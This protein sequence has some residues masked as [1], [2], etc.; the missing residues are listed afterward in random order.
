MLCGSFFNSGVIEE[1]PNLFQAKND[2][3]QFKDTCQI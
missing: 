1:N 3:L 2:D